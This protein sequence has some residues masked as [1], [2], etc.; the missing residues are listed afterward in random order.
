HAPEDLWPW[1]DKLGDQQSHFLLKQFIPSSVFHIDSIV[2]DREVKFAKAH[3]YGA[4]PLDVSHGG[5]V[6]TTRT[7]PREA[8]ETLQLKEI[9]KS[10]MKFLILLRGVT[11]REFLK[12]HATKQIYFL[13][14]AARV[15]G[16]YI[17]DVIETATSINLWRE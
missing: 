14:I 7:L 13:E 4:P 8:A 10:L 5:G 16:A 11:H 15:G 3:A 6:F 12:A 1:L 17:A 2:S 9:N